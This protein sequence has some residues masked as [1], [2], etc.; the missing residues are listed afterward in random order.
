MKPDGFPDKVL[1]EFLNSSDA[2][3][4]ILRKINSVRSQNPPQNPTGVQSENQHCKDLPV[5]D[6]V[7]VQNKYLP[8]LNQ[9]VIKKIQNSIALFI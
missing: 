4:K 5:K 8:N 3:C 7:K 6:P 9:G 2:I 1:E